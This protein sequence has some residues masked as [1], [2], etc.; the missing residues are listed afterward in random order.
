MHVSSHS[1]STSPK[2][3]IESL[4]ERNLKYTLLFL[5]LKN[6]KVYMFTLYLQHLPLFVC[7]RYKFTLQV[8]CKR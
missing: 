5:N 7:L 8:K 3:L 4:I 6:K 2:I 1:S